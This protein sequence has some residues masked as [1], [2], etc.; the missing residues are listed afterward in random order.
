MAAYSLN[1]L[2]KFNRLRNTKDIEQVLKKGRGLKEGFL[3]LKLAKNEL[4]AARF[5]FVISRKIS[6][7]ASVRNAV[8]RRLREAVRPLLP[9]AQ[10]G[11][12]AV[13]MAQKGI[14]NKNFQE[15]KENAEKIF[16]KSGII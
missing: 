1:M 11:F 5:A 12:D 4:E 7:K 3:F 6:K 15:I 9:L 8:K 16:K 10:A 2:P 13:V 14:E